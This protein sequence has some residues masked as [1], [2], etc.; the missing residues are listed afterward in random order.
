[1]IRWC[2]YCQSFLGESPPYDDPSLTH[3]ICEACDARLERREPVLEET[4]HARSLVNRLMACAEAGDRLG[5]DAILTEAR[6]LGLGVDS[7]LVGLLQ[8][9]LYRVGNEWQAARMSVAAEH[10]FTSWCEHAFSA[11][12]APPPARP[13]DLLI[14]QPPGNAHTLGPRFAAGVLTARGLAVEAVVPALPLAEMVDLARDLR[15]RFIGFSC[16]LPESVPVAV[17]LVRSLRE[18]LEPELQCRYVL[19]GFAF[20]LGGGAAPPTLGPGIEVAVDLDFFRA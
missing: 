11:L 6:A 8:P 10:R 5:A 4:A 12:P 18:R 3:T 16:A 14:F 15:P 13:L 7:L 9:V 2:S 1:M 17:E 19:S 20:R